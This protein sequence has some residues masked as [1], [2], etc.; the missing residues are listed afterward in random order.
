MNPGKFSWI[1][2]FLIISLECQLDIH[3]HAENKRQDDDDGDNRKDDLLH[4]NPALV[5][6]G[7]ALSLVI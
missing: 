5:P 1:H 6:V 7:N 4:P 3:Y 2:G